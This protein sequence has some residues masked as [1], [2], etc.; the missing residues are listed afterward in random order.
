MK[1]IYFFLVLLVVGICSL[2]AA[3]DVTKPPTA[4]ALAELAERPPEEVLK[5]LRSALIEAWTPARGALPGAAMRPAFRQW[6]R[7]AAWLDLL[8]EAEIAAWERFLGRHLAFGNR[9]GKEAIFLRLP[10]QEFSEGLMPLPNERL[11]K[12]AAD[13]AQ[14]AL[15][16]KCLLPEGFQFKGGTTGERLPQALRAIISNSADFQEELLANLSEADFLPGVFQIL[17]DLYTAN[18]E[19][20]LEY[21]NL[22]LALAMVYDQQL[23][24]DWPHHQVD[25]ALIPLRKPVPSRLFEEWI[26]ANESGKLLNDLRKLGVDHLKFVVDA[27]VE[28]SE[29]EWARKNVRLSRANFERAFSG[30]KYDMSRVKQQ[31]FD[32]PGKTPYTLENIQKLGGICVDQAYFAMLAGKAKGLPT[33][34]FVGQGA[35]GGHAWFGYLQNENRWNL[36]CGRYENQNY[37]TGS[38]MD[39]QTWD[40]I[41]DH[42]LKFLSAR[43]RRT[44]PFQAGLTDALIAEWHLREGKTEDALR[45]LESALAVSPQNPDLWEAKATLL[46]KSGNIEALAKHFD[47]ATKAF[48][49]NR[50][51]Q[52][53]FQFAHVAALREAG[54]T[55]EADALEKKLIAQNRRG[56]SDV[57]VNAFAGRIQSL[58]DAGKT[59]DALK[60]FRM[61]INRLG[62][63]GGGDFFYDVVSPLVTALVDAGKKREAQ[64]VLEMTRRSLNPTRG[65]ILDQEITKLEAAVK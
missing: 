59:D 14:R 37:A 35:D 46:A 22:A 16:S 26:A 48:Q 55:D 3:I 8:L 40:K 43:I 25:P 50:D 41:T 38:A 21:G 4:A 2:R 42:E 49:G 47:Q 52:T 15:Y 27:P 29:F 60:E 32:W 20:F 44:E 7:F 34:F 61:E 65:Q 23:P 17:A 28:L 1:T 33:L 54:H 12:I 64:R 39:P 63:T 30:I 6:V 51:L 10:G 11:R 36:D 13:P 56:R 9:D 5:E 62:K 19:K 18:P 31:Q 58:I 24:P 53:R 45:T 57:S